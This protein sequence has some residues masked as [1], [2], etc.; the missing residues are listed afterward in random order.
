MWFDWMQV[1]WTWNSFH[2]FPVNV[3]HVRTILITIANIDKSVHST[4]VQVLDTEA[5]SLCIEPTTCAESNIPQAGTIH[6]YNII[7]SAT[8]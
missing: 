8:R 7:N 3:V 4:V 2:A 6:S 1:C 5:P